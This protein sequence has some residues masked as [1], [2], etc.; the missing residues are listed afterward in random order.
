MNGDKKTGISIMK[1][2]EGLDEGPTYLQ[3]EIG[4]GQ[5]DNFTS[6]TSY[7]DGDQPY[8]IILSNAESIDQAYN[9]INPQDVALLNTEQYL[10]MFHDGE[11]DGKFSDNSTAAKIVADNICNVSPNKPSSYTAY[12]FMSFDNDNEIV[13][14]PITAGIGTS[15]PILVNNQVFAD[16]LN[17]LLRKFDEF[18]NSTKN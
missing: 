13:D 18:K 5:N 12:A 14:L 3:S 16:N 8:W 4:I 17:D 9:G 7:A 10:V 1:I 6:H 2:E 11:Y 15:S